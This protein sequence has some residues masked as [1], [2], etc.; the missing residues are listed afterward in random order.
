MLIHLPSVLA[1]SH[2]VNRKENPESLRGVVTHLQDN[3]FRAMGINR[4]CFLFKETVVPD[5]ILSSV[6]NPSSVFTDKNGSDTDVIFPLDD[7]KKM[8]ASTP[9]YLTSEW[10]EVDIDKDSSIATAKLIGSE[11]YD[12]V[13][14]FE[15]ILKM[16]PWRHIFN[17]SFP[18]EGNRVSRRGIKVQVPLDSLGKAISLSNKTSFNTGIVEIYLNSASET[19]PLSLVIREASD[20]EI[21]IEGFI[22]PGVVAETKTDEIV[23][24]VI[25]FVKNQMEE[26]HLVKMIK[27]KF[28]DPEKLSQFLSV[29]FGQQTS[30]G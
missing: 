26:H 29:H 22:M 11:P 23:D 10:W 12:V 2:N 24:Q 7:I 8:A 25:S 9:K 19:K 1:V 20:A 4:S 14:K 16:S 18:V 6:K 3:N 27:E 21:C 5:D 17:G 15:P 30:N 13:V 28:P